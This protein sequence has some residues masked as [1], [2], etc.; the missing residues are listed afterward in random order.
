MT[1]NKSK[2]MRKK[3]NDFRISLFYNYLLR[4]FENESVDFSCLLE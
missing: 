2:K 3:K 1:K 4:L